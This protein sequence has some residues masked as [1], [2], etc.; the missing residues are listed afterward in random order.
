MSRGLCYKWRD[1]IGQ[2]PAEP[3]PPGVHYD[4][5]TGPAPLRPFTK[6]PVPLQL[7]LELGTGNGDLGNQGIHEVDLARWGLGVTYRRRS[8]PS[9]DISCSMTTSR[10]QTSDGCL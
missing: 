1:T 7:A 10:R 9:A 5:W 4:L 6:K 8:R 3:V 2:Q